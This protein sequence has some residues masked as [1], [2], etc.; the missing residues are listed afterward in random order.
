[1]PTKK[2]S[3][4]LP[5]VPPVN[6]S[7]SSRSLEAANQAR[8]EKGAENRQKVAQLLAMGYKPN[9]ISRMMNLG[10]WTVRGYIED[11]DAM[12]QL[13]A[14]PSLDM[15]IRRSV[16]QREM[17]IQQAWALFHRLPDAAMNK[18]ATLGLVLQARDGIDKLEGTNAPDHVNAAAAA[19]MFRVFMDT[20]AEVGGVD[21]QTQ[22][23]QK[24]AAKLGRSQVGIVAGALEAPV[25]DMRKPKAADAEDDGDT[26]S[27]DD[28]I[29]DETDDD[30]DSDAT[31]ED[32][33][34]EA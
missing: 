15:R 23:M 25:V 11:I 18:S 6:K 17:V 21:M 1:M 27:E 19:E 29:Y 2:P 28:P 30:A 14:L 3:N 5:T 16:A 33:E 10:Y 12:L 32:G 13:D 24:L 31:D 22:V 4:R 9:E 26:D 34:E 7:L 20:A 8:K